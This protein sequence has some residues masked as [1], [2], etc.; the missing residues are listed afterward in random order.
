MFYYES[1]NF[2]KKT[3]SKYASF[4]NIFFKIQL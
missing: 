1:D 4:L 2:F 3:K